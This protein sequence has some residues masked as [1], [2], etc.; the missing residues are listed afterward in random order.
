METLLRDHGGALKKPE[1]VV[2]TSQRGF[3][4]E[5]DALLR[6]SFKRKKLRSSHRAHGCSRSGYRGT[7]GNT[8]GR[9]P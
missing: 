3:D 1:V 2:P 5:Q 8:R 7:G 4:K 6:I 9:T